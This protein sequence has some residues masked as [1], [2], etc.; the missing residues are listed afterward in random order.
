MIDVK[1]AAPFAAV[2]GLSLHHQVGHF[3]LLFGR[4]GDSAGTSGTEGL[5]E[6]IIKQLID[7]LVLVLLGCAHGDDYHVNS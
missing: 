1:V 2:S 6:G 5:P 4:G 3:R 7:L